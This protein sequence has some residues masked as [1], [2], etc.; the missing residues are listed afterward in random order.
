[1]CWYVW[2]LGVMLVCLGI[3]C[4]MLVCLCIGC[5]M[6][7]CLS[8][9]CSIWLEDVRMQIENCGLLATTSMDEV[10]IVVSEMNSQVGAK[11]IGSQWL[12][13]GCGYGRLMGDFRI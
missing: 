13:T 4:H 6:L 9:I 11:S 7:V 12:Y 10:L 3:G 1:M 5:N 8:I 2:V